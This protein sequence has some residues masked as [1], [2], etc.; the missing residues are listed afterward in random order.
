MIF[1]RRNND[2]FS[3]LEGISAAH[4]FF[5]LAEGAFPNHSYKYGTGEEYGYFYSDD[6]E[7]YV[8]FDNRQR[9]FYVGVFQRYED[10]I[11]QLRGD[12]DDDMFFA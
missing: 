11:E 2:N 1:R 10:A 7:G 5:E 3:P 8:V 9:T 6:A 12:D 4:K